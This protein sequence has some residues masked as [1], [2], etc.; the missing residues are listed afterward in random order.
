MIS[1]LNTEDKNFSND[2]EK[3]LAW[4]SVANSDVNQTV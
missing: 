2:L 4:E 3:L 1:K